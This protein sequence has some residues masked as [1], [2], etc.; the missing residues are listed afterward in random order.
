MEITVATSLIQ[1]GIPAEKSTWA[2]I[3]AGTGIFTLALDAILPAD[4]TIIALDKSPHPLYYL[5]LQ[6]CKLKIEE[7]DF[8]QPLN[9]PLLDGILMANALHYAKNPLPILQ[10]LIQ[11]LR[12]GGQFVLVEYE[13]ESPIIPWV[14]FPVPQAQF[15]QLA[16]KVGLSAPHLIGNIPSVYN[17][18][19]IY[20]AACQL[21]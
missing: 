8:S 4:S 14:P 5:H 10:N 11:Y 12:P 9:L 16:N 15:R 17:Q 21:G 13:R 19:Q 7:G 6:K 20:A 18:D 2:D 3:G 1:G